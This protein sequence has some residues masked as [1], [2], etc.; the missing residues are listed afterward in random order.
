[1]LTGFRATMDV[2]DSLEPRGKRGGRS[3]ALPHKNACA[4]SNQFAASG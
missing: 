1:L 3:K 2:V 4:F